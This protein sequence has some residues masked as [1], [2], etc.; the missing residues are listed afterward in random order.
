MNGEF[1]RN[2]LRFE[3][4][5]DHKIDTGEKTASPFKPWNPLVTENI[6]PMSF[7]QHQAMVRD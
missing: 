4:F 7:P 3:I 2:I 6:N 1:S 5:D